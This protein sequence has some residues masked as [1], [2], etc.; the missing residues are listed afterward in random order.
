MLRHRKVI[1]VVETVLFAMVAAFLG[2]RL[3]AVLGKRT[4]HEQTLGK[5]AEEPASVPVAA[6]AGEPREAA[7]GRSVLGDSFDTAATSGLRAIAQTDPRFHPTEFVDGAKAAYGM[8]LDAFWKGDLPALAPYVSA[9]VHQSFA[10]AVAAR[11]AAGEVL[12]N[13][14]V[15]IDRALISAASLNGRI[16]QIT[17]RFDADISAVTRDQHGAV[18]A[19][20]LT[21]AIET[22]DEWTFE[23]DLRSADPNWVLID[24]D[25]A[26]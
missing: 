14:L 16:A 26:A 6:P 24:T 18:I 9:D 15:R 3:F 20:S 4:G 5:P 23:R 10:D 2:L 8:I 22:H 11:E 21:D 13:R 17:V 7:S 19:G 12:D 25:E 1:D